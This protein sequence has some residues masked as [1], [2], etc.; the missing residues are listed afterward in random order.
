M[1]WGGDMFPGTV[2]VYIQTYTNAYTQTNP[3]VDHNDGQFFR[4][5]EWLMLFFKSTIAV[6][7]FSMVLTKLDHHH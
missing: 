5:M 7:G 2:W 6:N 4:A 3:L 1:G